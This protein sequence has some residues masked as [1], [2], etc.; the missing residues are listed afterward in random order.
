VLV[1]DATRFAR[2]LVAQELGVLLLSKRGISLLTTHGDDLTDD[3][4]RV[5]MRQIAG[6][7]AEYEKRRLVRKLR[8]ARER[9]GKRGPVHTDGP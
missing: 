6:S 5:M 2:K 8:E 7:F 4:G 1:E 9:S 3:E